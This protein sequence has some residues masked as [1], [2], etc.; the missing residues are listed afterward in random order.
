MSY[1]TL[2]LRDDSLNFPQLLLGLGVGATC[3]QSSVQLV[4]QRLLLGKLLLQRPCVVRQLQ[5]PA[6]RRWLQRRHIPGRTEVGSL[7]NEA[8]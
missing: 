5:G 4:E 7:C 6:R 8:S 3:I 2:Q 1:L